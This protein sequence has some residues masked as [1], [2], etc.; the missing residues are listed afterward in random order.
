MRISI[1]EPPVNIY[2]NNKKHPFYGYRA[3][4]ESVGGKGVEDE[5][6]IGDIWKDSQNSKEEA[7]GFLVCHLH[8]RWTERKEEEEYYEETKG[9]TKS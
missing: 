9:K 6:K 4:L 8:E 7:I 5:W 2:V 1:C 3:V